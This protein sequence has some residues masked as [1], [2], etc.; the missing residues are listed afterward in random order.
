MGD[1]GHGERVPVELS[2][3]PETLLWTLY[4]RASEARRPDGVLHDPLAVELL[5]R[6]DFPFEQRFGRP[7]SILTQV[8]GLRVRCFDREVT[9]FLAEHPDGTVVALGEGLETQFWRVDNGRVRWLTVDLPEVTAL[10]SRLLPDPPGS[11]VR[12]HAG[13]AT[14]L[15]WM[16]EVDATGGV[17]VVAQGLFMY[18]APPQVRRLIA[19]CADRFPVGGL[20]FDA[21]PHWFAAAA[22]NG[23]MR[24]PTGYL[25]PPMPWGLD[26]NEQPRLREVHPNITEVRDLR[27]PRGRGVFGRVLPRVNL[28]PVLRHHRPSA[29]A[30]RFDTPERSQSR[31]SGLDVSG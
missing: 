11:R 4:Y 29:V 26:V 23:R 22:T 17:L 7:G 14:D 27:P 28:V 18:L 5:D 10:R 13:S 15:G 21:V 8:Q 20:V 1:A 2:G 25:A 19:A 9:R 30:L 6:I 24:A 31:S 3:V 16:D 12:T